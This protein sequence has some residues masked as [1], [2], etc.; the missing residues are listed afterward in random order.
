[1]PAS[2]CCR[3]RPHRYLSAHRVRG[4]PADLAAL[5]QSHRTRQASG[6]EIG[7]AYSW[8]NAWNAALAYCRL[9]RA[10]WCNA[11]NMMNEYLQLRRPP[12]RMLGTTVF[13]RR[14]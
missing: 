4:R 3:Q 13:K 5:Q 7:S 9:N 8:G 1:M 14:T 11:K 6:P 12:K 10:L 2:P